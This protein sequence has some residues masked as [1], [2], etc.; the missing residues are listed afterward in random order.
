MVVEVA[1]LTPITMMDFLSQ[2]SVMLP[3][4]I[5]GLVV[6]V[7]AILFIFVGS[8]GLWFLMHIVSLIPGTGFLFVD[9]T[10]NCDD[11]SRNHRPPSPPKPRGRV[12]RSYRTDPRNRNL[13]HQLIGMLRGDT[14]LAKRLLRQQ[15]QMHPGRS[16]NWYLE[17]VIYDL[18]RD[19]RC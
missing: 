13:Q 16:D 1:L 15:R 3:P 19:R 8:L 17:K 10:G 12:S 5:F 7:L 2:L 6:A 9:L 4:P 18:E 11:S 14:A